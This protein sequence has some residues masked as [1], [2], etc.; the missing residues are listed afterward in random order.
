MR[1]RDPAFLPPGEAVAG[2]YYLQHFIPPAESTYRDCRVLVS[3]GRAVAAM[4]REHESWITNVHQGARCV[5]IPA[6]GEVA[7]LAVAAAEAV[8]AFHAGVDLILGADGLWQVLE[9]NSMP[10]CSGLQKVAP[11]RI[12][13]VL[14]GD[15]VAALRENARHVDLA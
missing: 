12:A 10:A 4:L 1:L 11:V 15:L 14:A 5:A 6:E 8:G 13:A 3:D 7:Q 9:V 2:I